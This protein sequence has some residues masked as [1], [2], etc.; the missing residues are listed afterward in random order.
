MI[1]EIITMD[2]IVY[3][4]PKNSLIIDILRSPQSNKGDFG[5]SIYFRDKTVILIPWHNTRH[6]IYGEG[7]SKREMEMDKME[8]ERKR[9]LT[10]E[11]IDY[12]TAKRI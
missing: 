10:R 7:K 2:G 12:H 1:I 5:H 11:I 4:E 9:E 3:N 6:V 8:K